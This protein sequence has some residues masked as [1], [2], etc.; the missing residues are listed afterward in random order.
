MSVKTFSD[1]EVKAIL[2]EHFV[3][4]E[5]NVDQKRDVASWFQ[6]EAIPDT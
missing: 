6:G 5:L 4:V 1:P 2:D 3:V